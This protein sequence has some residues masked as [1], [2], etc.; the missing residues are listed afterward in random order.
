MFGRIDPGS[1]VNVYRFSPDRD[2]PPWDRVTVTWRDGDGRFPR[3]RRH[4]DSD[5]QTPSAS[6]QP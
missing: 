2:L 5:G 4:W 6:A 3:R 1:A